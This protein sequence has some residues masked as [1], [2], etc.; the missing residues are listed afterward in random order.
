MDEKLRHEALCDALAEVLFRAA[1]ERAR[2]CTRGV[3]HGA[4][5]R[6]PGGFSFVRNLRRREAQGE[7]I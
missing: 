6:Q 3:R 1:D 5:V 4:E 7:S 2:G